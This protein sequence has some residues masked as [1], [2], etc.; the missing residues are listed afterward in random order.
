MTQRDVAMSVA[1]L[2]PVLLAKLSV[3]AASPAAVVP[4]LQD[5]WRGPGGPG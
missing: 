2:W 4:R 5:R 3:P 1:D